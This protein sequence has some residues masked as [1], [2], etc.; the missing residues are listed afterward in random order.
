MKFTTI[1]ITNIHT[2]K[3]CIFKNKII[4]VEIKYFISSI[5]FLQILS[6]EEGINH[7]KF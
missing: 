7:Y 4:I 5:I 6:K 3:D 2:K 1:I